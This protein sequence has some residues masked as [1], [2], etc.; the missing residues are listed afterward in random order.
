MS[1]SRTSLIDVF[2]V[3]SIR[4]KLCKSFYLLADTQQVKERNY[5]RVRA[6]SATDA[7]INPGGYASTHSLLDCDIQHP[8]LTIL[9]AAL[10]LYFASADG[11]SAR[12]DLEADGT[13]LSAMSV[14]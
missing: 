2:A 14:Q 4:T 3:L 10:T 11:G 13:I 5:D 1:F 7:M 9:Y 12:V 6:C 8:Y